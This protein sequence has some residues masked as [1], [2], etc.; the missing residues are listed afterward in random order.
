MVILG[1]VVIALV[2]LGVKFAEMKADL[3][4]IDLT[5]CD[6]MQFEIQ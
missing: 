6:P 5:Y 1:G 3:N 2:V 4:T